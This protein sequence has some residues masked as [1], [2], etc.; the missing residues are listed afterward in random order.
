MSVSE[1]VSDE[2]VSMLSACTTCRLWAEQDEGPYHR[3]APART[4]RHRRRPRRCRTA[5]RHPPRRRTAT[6]A[7]RRGDRGGLAVRR[8]RPL[9]RLPAARSTR[10]SSPPT[11]RRVAST[12][13]TRP[14]F[15]AARRTDSSGHGRV[16]H[17]LSRLVSRPHR[18]HPSDGPRRRRGPDQ[19]ALLPRR[20]SATR[21]SRRRRTPS[22]RAA[23]RP[24]PPTR[25]SRPAATPPCST[26]SRPA[27]GTAPPS[28]SSLPDPGDAS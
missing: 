5:A 19:P 25:S 28:A 9:L 8:A 17:D 3:D 21:S 18:A 7:G 26:S 4:A 12:C 14:S 10:P 16:P 2:L 27:T 6:P 11:P 24:T 22:A 23:T 13:R 1:P 15:A 20:R